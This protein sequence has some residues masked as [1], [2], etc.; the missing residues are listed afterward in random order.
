MSSSFRNDRV[1][2]AG[3]RAAAAA[4]LLG[5]AGPAA[6]DSWTLKPVINVG[7]QYETNPR[8]QIEAREDEALGLAAGGQLDA[9][10]VSDRN[11]VRLQPRVRFS[12]YE[13]EADEDLEEDNYYLLAEAT[14]TGLR[15]EY[16]LTARWSDVNI[17]TGQL[18][19][20]LDT[21]LPPGSSDLRFINNK[22]RAISF[23][24][25]WKLRLTPRNSL[26]LSGTYDDVEFDDSGFGTIF[27]DYE[28][29]G[30][31]ASLESALT[32]KLG[33]GISA[34]V[35][36]FTSAAPSVDTRVD[37]VFFGPLFVPA[38]ALENESTSFNGS[39]FANYRFTPTIT[40]TLN[41][42]VRRTEIDVTRE[43]VSAEGVCF[44]F[45]PEGALPPLFAPTPD[46]VLD[47]VVQIFSAPCSES[48]S[49][50][51][52][53]GEG[54]LERRTDRNVYFAS[55]SRFVVPNVNGFET[56]RDTLSLRLTRQL[57]RSRLSGELGLLYFEQAIV[58]DLQQQKL[59]YF[60][61]DA[62]LRW[63]MTRD[64]GVT[65]RYFFI[66]RDLTNFVGTTLPADNHFV[67]AAFEYRP[68]GWRF[69]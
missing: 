53:V 35:N 46:G 21:G 8:L 47:Q 19:S 10:W 15:S 37:T 18:D 65:L 62:V 28:N 7:P 58:A 68:V 23:A 48:T 33:V 43:P 20:A 17:R 67:Y 59:D 5:L 50:T 54:S 3:P 9:V 56:I 51:S 14:R 38:S 22:Q 25:F 44:Q 31:V 11:R 45:I 41:A 57:D 29:F 12:R 24:P 52:F 66:D 39:V 40:A 2:G 63:R 30:A 49:D 32:A 13:E 64:W 1:P 60:R 26:T 42:G 69:Q 4:L 55:I 27:F 16:G 36:Q 61:F 34:T 6:A